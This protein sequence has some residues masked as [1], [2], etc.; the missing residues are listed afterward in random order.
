M[1]LHFR[2]IAGPMKGHRFIV[3]P[4]SSKCFSV[5]RAKNSTICIGQDSYVSRSHAR[6]S[7]E[8]DQFFIEDLRSKNGTYLKG[9]LITKPMQFLPESAVVIGKSILRFDGFNTKA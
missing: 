7:V 6:I 5:G 2:L 4:N 9:K 3:K 1:I 8:K